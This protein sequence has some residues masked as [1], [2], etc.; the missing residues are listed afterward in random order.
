MSH[1][2]VIFGTAFVSGNGRTGELSR[3][4]RREVQH[5]CSKLSLINGYKLGS[6]MP[7]LEVRR[8]L[9][10]TDKVRKQPPQRS[11]GLSPDLKIWCIYEY[12]D[13][14]DARESQR[15]DVTL[16]DLSSPFPGF[17]QQHRISRSMATFATGRGCPAFFPTPQTE[18]ISYPPAE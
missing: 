1:G 18:A 3:Y 8:I 16:K 11:S 6:R 15:L 12:H 17:L 7:R 13:D 4:I 2:G 10:V 14:M 5:P 9:T